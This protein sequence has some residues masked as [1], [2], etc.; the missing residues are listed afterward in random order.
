VTSNFTI[1]QAFKNTDPET[2]KA[3]NRRF[4][5]IHKLDQ[6]LCLSDTD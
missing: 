2:I 6:N 1:D 3:L 4:K 5:K